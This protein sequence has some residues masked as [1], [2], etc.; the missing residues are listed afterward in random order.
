MQP[1]GLRRDKCAHHRD[2]GTHTVVVEVVFRYPDRVVTAAIHDFDSFQRA[3][4]D[5][6]QCGTP[7]GPTEELED[8]EFHVSPPRSL[9]CLKAI[10]RTR[11]DRQGGITR[12][13]SPSQQ[14]YRYT[15]CGTA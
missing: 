3:F 5:G 11:E 13:I 8:A 10:V 4:V 12:A 2:G 15:S 14:L 1:F 7:I 9:P 6:R